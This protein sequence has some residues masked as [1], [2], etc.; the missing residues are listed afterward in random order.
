MGREDKRTSGRQRSSTIS[1]RGFLTGALAGAAFSV[2]PSHVLAG[3]GEASP[4]DRL[5]VAGVG[6]GGMGKNNVKKSDSENIVALCDVDHKHAKGIIDKYPDAKVWH[7]YREMLAQQDEID[8][9]IC[10]TPDHTHAVI[11]AAAMKAGKHVYTQKPLTHSVWEA[12]RLRQ[13][14]NDTGVSTQ[15]GNQGH[16]AGNIRRCREWIEGGAIGTVREVHCWTNRPIWPQGK[17]DNKEKPAPD[18]LKWDLW[19]GPAQK[20]PYSPIYHPFSWRGWRDFGTGAFGDMGCHLMD[21]P[22]YALDLGHPTYAEASTTKL[23]PGTFPERTI[24]TY[25]FPP[26]D[27]RPGITFK[28]YSGEVKPPLPDEAPADAKLDTQGCMLVGDDGTLISADYGRDP[29][30]YPL[31]RMKSARDIP[32]EYPRVKTTHEK[33]WIRAA[34]KGEQPSSN[35]DYATRLTETVLLGNIAILSGRPIKWDA[36]NLKVTNYE[37]ANRY[38]RGEYR[39]GWSL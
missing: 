33:A 32:K 25:E 16:S 20:R 39:D 31:S 10:A 1:R 37:K 30:I 6:V 7:D 9:V 27:G 26:R 12:R 2:V 22:Y 34:K 35:F 36:E 23:Y 17:V 38:V 28:W 11:T 18:H 5:N 4:S 3:S 15:M 24:V 19:L 13:I 29:R 21:M 14:A 8:A